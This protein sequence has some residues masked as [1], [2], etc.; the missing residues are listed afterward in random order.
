MYNGH[1][2]KEILAMG[3]KKTENPRP[4]SSIVTQRRNYHRSLFYIE[5]LKEVKFNSITLNT[6]GTSAPMTENRI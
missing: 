3:D 6:W 2:E 4:F 1:K 5:A